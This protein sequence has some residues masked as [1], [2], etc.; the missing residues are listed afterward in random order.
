MSS[1]QRECVVHDLSYPW[2]WM[3]AFGY[4]IC[5][6]G[7]EI[8]TSTTYDAQVSVW[9]ETAKDK[10]GIWHDTIS[11]ACVNICEHALRKLQD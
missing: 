10:K 4:L 1:L 3:L 6:H 5:V 8:C 9:T 7:E 2:Q 11:F